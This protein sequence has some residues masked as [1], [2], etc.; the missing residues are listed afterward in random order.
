MLLLVDLL[1]AFGILV[2]LGVAWNNHRRL[3][4]LVE[5]EE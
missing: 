3:N 4:A 1:W 5:Y 2:A